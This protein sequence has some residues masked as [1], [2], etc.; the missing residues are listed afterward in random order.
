MHKKRRGER[1]REREGERMRKEKEMG[2]RER[3]KEK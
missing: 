2:K 1:G 3:M